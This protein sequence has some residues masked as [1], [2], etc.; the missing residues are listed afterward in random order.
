MGRYDGF[1]LFTDVDGTLMTDQ[2][3]VPRANAEAIGRFIGQGG[4]LSLA[5]G[6]GPHVS[7]RDIAAQIG[8]NA[9]CVLLNGSMV[10]DFAAKKPLIVGALPACARELADRIAVEF[11]QMRI[12]IWQPDGRVEAN[13]QTIGGISLPWLKILLTV[14]P[15]QLPHICETLQSWGYPGIRLTS[16]CAYFVEIM[17]ENASKGAGIEFLIGHMKLERGRVAVAGDYFN[18][19]EMLTLPG[20]RAFCPSNAPEEIQRICE[21]TLCHVDEGAIAELIDLL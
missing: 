19:L 2:Y 13:A 5:T 14:E 10:Y 4:R 17:P 20:I 7:T 16:S 1:V 15:R 6:R 9:P 21:R 3:T 11:P 12:G 8:V 18:D